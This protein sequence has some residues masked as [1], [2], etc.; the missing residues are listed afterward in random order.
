MYRLRTCAEK[1]RDEPWEG[2]NMVNEELAEVKEAFDVK[3]EFGR[4]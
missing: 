3:E 1:W 2:M 4:L